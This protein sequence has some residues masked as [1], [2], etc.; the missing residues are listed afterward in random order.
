MGTTNTNLNELLKLDPKNN[1]GVKIFM[2]SSTGEMLVD[3]PEAL[4]NIFSQ[5]KTLIATHCEDDPTIQRNLA[6]YIEKYGDDI[7]VEFH[8]MIRSEEA[9]YKSSSLLLDLQKA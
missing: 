2:G 9:C 3:D 8:P 1:C 7:P 4:E 6:Q 5:V